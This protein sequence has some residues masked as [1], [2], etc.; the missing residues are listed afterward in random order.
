MRFVPHQFPVAACRKTPAVLKLQGALTLFHW[1]HVLSHMSSVKPDNSTTP[2]SA[3]K[4][5]LLCCSAI[6]ILFWY[7]IPL[8]KKWWNLRVNT[9][10]GQF[11]DF[12]DVSD[13]ARLAMRLGPAYIALTGMG[14][15]LRRERAEK[16][17]VLL[18][19][20]SFFK[21]QKINFLMPEPV[22]FYYYTGFKAVYPTSNEAMNANYAVI[23]R[24]K[25]LSLIPLKDSAIR[26]ACIFALTQKIPKS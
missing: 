22:I 26:A 21:R 15:F 17:L 19:E 8:N 25:K 12:T 24:K 4:W 13:S 11:A 9:F 2:S 7:N 20:Q 16:V 23:Y 18:P 6:L 3:K 5:I 14:N 1:F 10:P